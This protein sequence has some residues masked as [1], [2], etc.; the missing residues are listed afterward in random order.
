MKVWR[1]IE[2]AMV[3]IDGIEEAFIELETKTLTVQYYENQ[4]NSTRI[5]STVKEAIESLGCD[6]EHI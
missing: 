2:K 3:S 6:V 5:E 4:I 1:K